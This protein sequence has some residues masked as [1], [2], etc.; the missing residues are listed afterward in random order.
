MKSIWSVVI[1]G[2]TGERELFYLQTVGRKEIYIFIEHTELGE[3]VVVDK[4]QGDLKRDLVQVVEDFDEL[5]S[6]QQGKLIYDNLMSYFFG[7]LG[8]FAEL[9]HFFF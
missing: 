4:V 5:K 3:D 9:P 8:L 2:D 6:E 7:D 1:C